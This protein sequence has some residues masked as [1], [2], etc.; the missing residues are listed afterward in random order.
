[1]RNSVIFVALAL[2]LFV[3]SAHSATEQIVFRS[4]STVS[5]KPHKDATITFKRAANGMNV[6]MY[7]H[8]TGQTTR[9]ALA[10]DGNGA[11]TTSDPELMNVAHIAAVSPQVLQRLKAGESVT[12]RGQIEANG[13][14]HRVSNQ[15]QLVSLSGSNA[16]V[17]TN[18][19]SENG[20]LKLQTK[21]V[22]DGNGLPLQAETRG[23][24]KAFLFSADIQVALKRVTG[25]TYSQLGGD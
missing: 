18:T 16:V 5:G 9:G 12:T 14:V 25:G 17:Q 1:M 8:D 3:E 21:A 13:K 22:V 20:K 15:H 7:N 2:S 19:R 23:R 4:Q 11:L 10:Y 6:S 24:F